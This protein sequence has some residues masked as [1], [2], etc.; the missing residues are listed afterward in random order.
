MWLDRW[1]RVRSLLLSEFTV[2]PCFLISGVVHGVECVVVSLL[3]NG[4]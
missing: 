1:G 3:I 4:G 2:S